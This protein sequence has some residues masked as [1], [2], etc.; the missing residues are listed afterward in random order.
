MRV[1]VFDDVLFLRQHEY[2][3]MEVEF[4]FF[5][6]ADEAV[7]VVA[8]ECPDLVLM[9]YAMEE[10]DTGEEAIEKLRK[11]WPRGDLT[12]VGISSDAYS[13]ERMMAAGADEAV[14]KSHIR[15]YLRGVMRKRAG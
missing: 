15:G 5:E 6:H 2:S 12:I 8:A 1:V 11:R 3:G 9:D 14:P 10:H 13:N 4:R 7:G